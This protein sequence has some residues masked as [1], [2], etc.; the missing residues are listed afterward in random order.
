MYT[1]WQASWR[2]AIG[3]GATYVCGVLLFAGPIISKNAPQR[4]PFIL[5]IILTA[6]CIA[7]SVATYR[8]VELPI[9]HYLKRQINGLTGRNPSKV[10][11]RV[12]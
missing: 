11:S 10:S 1:H 9:H 3:L 4:G 6:L 12:T 7:A 8:M 2:S 5:A